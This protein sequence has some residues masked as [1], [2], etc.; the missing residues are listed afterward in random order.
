MRRLPVRFREEAIA[1]L[2]EVIVYLAEQGAD[3]AVIRGFINRIRRQCEKVGDAPE[4]Y[5]ARE[6][7]GPGIRIVPFERS[8]VIAYRIEQE[9]V[10]IVNVFYGGRD[11]EA[12]MK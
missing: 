5:P 4:G 2:E 9:K 10:E 12:L 3:V 7:L 8:A 11:Y 1:D 6:D